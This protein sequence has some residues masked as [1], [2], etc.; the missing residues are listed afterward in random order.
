LLIKA[1]LKRGDVFITNVVKCRPPANRR[2]KKGELDA[3]HP[4]LRRQIDAIRP[5]VVVLLGDTALKEF[6]PGSTLGELHGKVTRRGDTRFFATYHPASIIY[7]RSLLDTL[8]KDF[9][10]LGEVLR[11]G[12]G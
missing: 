7:N 1:G 3:C 12:S 4:Y 10:S 9:A 5:Q 8:E 11:G 6:F 2:P